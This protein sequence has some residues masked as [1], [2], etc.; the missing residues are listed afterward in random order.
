MKLKK[1]TIQK[2]ERKCKSLQLLSTKEE[3]KEVFELTLHGI[4]TAPTTRPGLALIKAKMS[5]NTML[6]RSFE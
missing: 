4:R 1:K 3:T 5:P 2:E 6:L